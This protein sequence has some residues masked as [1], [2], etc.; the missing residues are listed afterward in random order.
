M[1]QLIREGCMSNNSNYEYIRNLMDVDNYMAYMLTGIYLNYT[2][3]G[4]GKHQK[5][6]RY[7]TEHG[8][9]ESNTPYGLD[10]RWRW[11]PLD[12]D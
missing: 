8:S 3:W 6:W 9:C 12:L 7:K 5:V 1:D 11:M 2:D 4:V 10:G